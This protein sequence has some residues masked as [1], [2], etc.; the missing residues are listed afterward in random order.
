MS[1][2]QPSSSSAFEVVSGL[3]HQ[4]C[5]S[6]CND[7]VGKSACGEKRS[8]KFRQADREGSL[9]MRTVLVTN[10]TEYA[11]PGA[12]KFWALHA[13]GSFVTIEAL[14]MTR[15]AGGISS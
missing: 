1:R 9:L 12:V 7:F 10:S 6:I 4:L 11:A 3:P 15:G 8:H 5:L 14:M 2:P 13:I